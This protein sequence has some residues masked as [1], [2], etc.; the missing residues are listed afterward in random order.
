VRSSDCLP[1]PRLP[2]HAAVRTI[3]RTTFSLSAVCVPGVGVELLLPEVD[4]LRLAAWS[5]V[6]RTVGAIERG[7]YAP[8]PAQSCERLREQLSDRTTTRWAGYLDGAVVG[9]AEVRPAGEPKTAFTR[10]YVLPDRRG[11]GVGRS[12]ITE[13]VR[14]GTAARC[15]SRLRTLL[16]RA[17][18]CNLRARTNGYAVRPEGLSR[19]RPT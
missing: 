13:V 11:H 5:D 17:S 10:I 1:T 9:T 2:L 19:A 3:V 4:D 12:L 15:P 7:E 14:G 16:A 6:I 8:A 18:I